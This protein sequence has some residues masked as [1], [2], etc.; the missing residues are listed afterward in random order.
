MMWV[1]DGQRVLPQELVIETEGWLRKYQKWHKKGTTKSSG[2]PQQWER[3]KVDW[4]KCDFNG[5]WLQ[6]GSRRGFGA[7]MRDH[8]G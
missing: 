2:P 4:V 3:P 7:V 5:A 1:W 8:R 6:Q